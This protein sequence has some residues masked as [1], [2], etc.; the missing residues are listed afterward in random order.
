MH[1]LC[2]C[3]CAC[4]LQLT[5]RPIDLLTRHCFLFVA[6]HRYVQKQGLEPVLLNTMDFKRKHEALRAER[7][8]ALQEHLKEAGIDDDD[9]DGGGGV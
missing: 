9:D 5:D 6:P 8:R 3:V 1:A 2:V 4:A 7:Q